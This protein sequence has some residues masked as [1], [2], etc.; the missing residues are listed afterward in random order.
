M[1]ILVLGLLSL[2]VETSVNAAETF[3][4]RVPLT[5]YAHAGLETKGVVRLERPPEASPFLSL[6]DT[7]WDISEARPDLSGKAPFRPDWVIWNEDTRRIVAKGSAMALHALHYH[8]RIENLPTQCR[9]RIEL[10]RIGKEIL[11]PDFSKKPDAVLSVVSRNHQT[12][13]ASYSDDGSRI[14]FK[15]EAAYSEDKNFIDL[16]LKVSA[17]LSGCP[18]LEIDCSAATRNGSEVWVARGH[19]G[20]SGIDVRIT[21]TIELADGTPFLK[22]TLKQNGNAVETFYIDVQNLQRIV[23]GGGLELGI[24]RMSPLDV[25]QNFGG[26]L[27]G[28]DP[29][30]IQDHDPFVMDM[31]SEHFHK[32]KAS[33]VLA[34]YFAGSVIDLTEGVRRSGILFGEGDSAGYDLSTETIFVLS[35]SPHELD[36]FAQLIDYGY[37]LPPVSCA[38]SHMGIGESRLLSRSGQKATMKISRGGDTKHIRHLEIEPT[39]GES[40][41]LVDLRI[42]YE[43]TVGKETIR[44]LD[45][46]ATLIVGQAVGLMG[47]ERVGGSKTDMKFKAEFVR[48]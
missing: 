10:F 32:I 45:T 7:L 13:I 38:I 1:K 48:D 22:A 26:S 27:P 20:E 19:D 24:A 39:I 11:P 2:V 44:T 16:K 46:A 8:M 4:W 28:V 18:E 34:P 41:N 36:K 6:G 43:E 42:S 25:L 21:P 33:E 37:R 17:T 12:S 3:A 30:D 9:N 14:Q 23:L 40:Y 29:F 5:N 35:A 47:E 15:G 31:L